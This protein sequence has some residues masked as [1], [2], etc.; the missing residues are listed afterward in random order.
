MITFGA[1]AAAGMPILGAIIGVV[2]IL[3]GLYPKPV[4]DVTSASVANLI[5]EYRT[6][7]A[8]DHAPRVA[9]REQGVVK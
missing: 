7:L 3:M 6:Q 4:F 2:T 9:T 8:L 5:T 1:F